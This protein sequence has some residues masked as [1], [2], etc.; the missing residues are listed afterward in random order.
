[1]KK[2]FDKKIEHDLSQIVSPAKRM[3]ALERLSEGVEKHHGPVIEKILTDSLSTDDNSVV[4]H[5]IAFLLGRLYGQGCINGHLALDALC[6]SALTDS[7]PLVRHEAAAS[8]GWFQN[9]KALQVLDELKRDP[10]PDVVA[11]AWIAIEQLQDGEAAAPSTAN[12]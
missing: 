7:S 3:D 11:T 2:E 8:L 1:M 9:Q 4:R 6:R 12:V 5:E 10:H